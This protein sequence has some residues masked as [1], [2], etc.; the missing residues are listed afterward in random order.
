MKAIKETMSIEVDGDWLEVSMYV[1]ETA[2]E[3]HGDACEM[4]IY[5]NGKSIA[6]LC[7]ANNYANIVEQ[8]ALLK[9]KVWHRVTAIGLQ[10]N[11]AFG[12]NE[13][14]GISDGKL[15]LIFFWSSY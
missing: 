11:T 14:F 2:D 7:E 15:Y 3:E 6:N 9:S 4:H 5:F 13:C 1:P 12:D 8:M 10:Y